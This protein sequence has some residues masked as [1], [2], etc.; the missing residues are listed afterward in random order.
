MFFQDT[1]LDEFHSSSE[2]IHPHHKIFCSRVIFLNRIQQKAEIV[3]EI[4]LLSVTLGEPY[5]KS[6]TFQKEKS[7]FFVE[8]L[9]SRIETFPYHPLLF[10]TR[11]VY[12][13][14]VSFPV[15]NINV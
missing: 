6:G 2:G 13:S 10:Q 5:S 11:N 1:K 14:L 12:L 9:S 15:R 7:H 4:V 3:G 8:T